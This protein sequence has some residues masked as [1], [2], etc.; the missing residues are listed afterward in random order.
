[1]VVEA[2]LH[3]PCLVGVARVVVAFSLAQALL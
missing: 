2:V 1:V 3:Q